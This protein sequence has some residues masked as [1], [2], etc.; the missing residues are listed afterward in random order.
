[1][2][3]HNLDHIGEAENRHRAAYMN[4]VLVDPKT[5]QLSEPRVCAG[6]DGTTITVGLVSLVLGQVQISTRKR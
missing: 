4:G 6:N 2:S 5:R 3:A 1:M